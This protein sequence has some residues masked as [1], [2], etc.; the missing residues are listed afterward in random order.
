VFGVLCSVPMKALHH[1]WPPWAPP[2]FGAP[3]W[4]R[5]TESR[6]TPPSPS[7]RTSPTR[8]RLPRSR[9][10]SLPP[11]RARPFPLPLRRHLPVGS[12]KPRLRL[13]SD[14]GTLGTQQ[15]RLGRL[16]SA[17]SPPMSAASAESRKPLP[18]PMSALLFTKFCCPYPRRPTRRFTTD[19]SLFFMGLFCSQRRARSGDRRRSRG[20]GRCWQALACLCPRRTR[21]TT[22]YGPL[23]PTVRSSP[24]RS[25]G[26]AVAL[27]RPTTRYVLDRT[28]VTLH[29]GLHLG[30]GFVRP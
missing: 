5:Q 18:S 13:R 20:Y 11:L 28:T 19:L 26:S 22:T 10:L 1:A 8:P 17:R 21:P 24:R 9:S 2:K 16:R 30:F 6:T 14:P 4:Q 12:V 23:S 27:L 29:A 3:T 25:A 15:Q 7:R